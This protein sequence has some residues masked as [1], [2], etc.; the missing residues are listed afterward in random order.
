MGGGE[1]PGYGGGTAKVKISLG[2]GLK[3][4]EPITTKSRKGAS[5]FG[6]DDEDENGA[7]AV[8]STSSSLRKP[9]IGPGLAPSSRSAQQRQD[10]ALALDASVFEYDG[11]Y[12][13]MK[14]GERRAEQER[15][16][17]RERRDPKY[18][19]ASL[20]AS[21]QRKLDRQRAEA[22]KIQ[23]EREQE[24]DQFANTEAFVTDAY[25]Q[26]MEE[27]HRDE[28][29]ERV[30]EEKRRREAK[31]EGGVATFLKDYINTQDRQHQAAVQAASSSVIRPPLPDDEQNNDEEKRTAARIQ[32]ARSKGLDVR[33]N[34]D[35]EVVDE[36][37]LLTA[38]LNTFPSN[39]RKTY[40]AS[41]DREGKQTR[42]A[43]N[44]PDLASATVQLPS[45]EQREA[46]RQRQSVMMQE[47]LLALQQQRQEQQAANVDAQ[48]AA[49]VTQ[50][51]NDEDRI[52]QARQRALERR[53]KRQDEQ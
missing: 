28:Q 45:R 42:I 34:D 5:V 44:G 48:K 33:V 15:Q 22:R 46:Q 36:R 31:K 16:R 11:V 37:S 47:Q 21:E 2:G 14:T 18:I 39:K 51:R 30:E 32:Q 41:Y 35:N 49:L 9:K 7:E 26:Q 24:G 29:C 13:S 50:R 12:D 8:A 27:M 38:G 19:A 17:E 43:A 6:L 4:V 3:K 10:E 1:G 20:A 52:A 53:K 23:R 40:D 25:R